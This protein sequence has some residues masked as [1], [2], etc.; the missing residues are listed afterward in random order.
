MEPNCD[1]IFNLLSYSLIVL[2]FF[3]AFFVVVF[4]VWWNWG[5]N[6]QTPL[7]QDFGLA[8]QVLY[9]LS[10]SSSSFCSSYFG[11]RVSR[12]ICPDWP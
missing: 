4:V 9:G 7:G 6:W 1:E 3:G 2:G 10:H 5:L 8:K 11:D 12:T